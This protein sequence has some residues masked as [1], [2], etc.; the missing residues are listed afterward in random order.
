MIT[1]EQTLC[2]LLY[3]NIAIWMLIHLLK[4]PFFSRHGINYLLLFLCQK[5]YIVSI[6]FCHPQVRKY[7]NIYDSIMFVAT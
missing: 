5:M 2:Q 3:I 1:E 7:V 4:G 6:A